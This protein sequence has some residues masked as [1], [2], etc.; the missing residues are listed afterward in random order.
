ME[1]MVGREEGLR[2]PGH[3]AA[4]GGACAPHGVCQLEVSAAALGSWKRFRF[5][6]W[7]LQWWSIILPHGSVLAFPV[8]WCRFPITG[9]VSWEVHR[10]RLHAALLQADAEQASHTEGSGIHRP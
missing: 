6:L 3:A 2:A 8:I 1:F 10:Y 7:L 9:A 5:A 4:L